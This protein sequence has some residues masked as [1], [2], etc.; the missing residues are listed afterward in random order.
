MKAEMPVRAISAPLIRPAATPIA[1]AAA[2]ARTGGN[3]Q[4]CIRPAK[5]IAARPPIAPIAKFICPM[6]MMTICDIAITTLTA[7][8]SMQDLD[9]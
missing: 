9:D 7:A 4:T 1:S 6:A 5:Q 8:A 3:D 2:A